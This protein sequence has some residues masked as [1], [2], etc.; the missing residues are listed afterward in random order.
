M[1]YILM[2]LLVA[3]FLQAQG[4]KSSITTTYE[5][6][7]FKNSIQKDY[8]V[9]YSVGGV[10]EKD[11]STYQLTLERTITETKK[12]PL[13]EN[14]LVSK[15]YAK[16]S[17]KFNNG[18]TINLNHLNVLNDNIAPTS[19]AKTYGAGIGY[20]FDKNNFVNFTQYY[21]DFRK[22][23]VYQSDLKYMHKIYFDSIMLKIT[24]IAKYMKLDDYKN[25]PFSKNADK[26]YLT[27]GV[28]LHA[29]YKDYHFG[30]G[31][32]FGDRVFS[33][34][35]DG[36]K[37]QHHAMEFKKTYMAGIGK[38]ISN[39]VVS[40]RYIYQEATELPMQNKDVKINN[41]VLSVK[42]KF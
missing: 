27:A 33:V 31:A 18:V 12:P 32:Y 2:P 6:L 41:T 23:N 39:F 40:L 22:F 26:D 35:K 7:D 28:K 15:L 8:G 14:L 1:K 42:Y 3:T 16:Y 37:L 17:H 24:T 13:K 19:H 30:A 10:V 9:R 11:N 25:N 34:M 36:F 29:H 5:S 4:V 21:T 38:N 20:F